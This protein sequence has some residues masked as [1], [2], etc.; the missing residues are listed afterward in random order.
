M[1]E[2]KN[3][4]RLAETSFHAT[5][6]S[7]NAELTPHL[8]DVAVDSAAAKGVESTKIKYELALGAVNKAKLMLSQIKDKIEKSSAKATLKISLKKRA[9]REIKAAKQG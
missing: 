1:Q 2:D 9:E 3:A 7:G 8:H 5:S 6:N 4:F